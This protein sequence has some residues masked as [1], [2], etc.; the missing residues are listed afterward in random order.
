MGNM[1]KATI[2]S[3]QDREDFAL[4]IG[5]IPDHINGLPFCTSVKRKVIERRRISIVKAEK[6][7]PNQ[8]EN[9]E[10]FRLCRYRAEQGF[11]TVGWALRSTINGDYFVFA[12]DW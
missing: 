11:V 1:V 3:K 5:V 7:A 9:Q 4:K 12:Q 8:S 2:L 6:P 10:L